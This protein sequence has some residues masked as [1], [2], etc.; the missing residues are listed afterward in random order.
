MAEDN[1]TGDLSWLSK[2]DVKELK[3]LHEEAKKNKRNWITYKN[4][5][6]STNFVYYFITYKQ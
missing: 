4:K 6:L 3:A 2:K 5:R 1:Y